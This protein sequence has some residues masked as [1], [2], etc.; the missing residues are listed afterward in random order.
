MPRKRR[1][2][3]ATWLPFGMMIGFTVGMGFSLI[4]TDSL[5]IAAGIGFLFGAVL[6]IVLGFR[7]RRGSASNDRHRESHGDPPR[8]HDDP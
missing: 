2:F 7:P 4:I 3:D 5:L 8:R 1:P 6:G